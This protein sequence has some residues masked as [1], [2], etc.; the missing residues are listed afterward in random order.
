MLNGALIQV[1]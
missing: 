1:K